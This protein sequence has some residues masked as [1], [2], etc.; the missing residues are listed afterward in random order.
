MRVAPPTAEPSDSDETEVSSEDDA[1]DEDDAKGACN[2]ENIPPWTNLNAV[3]LAVLHWIATTTEEIWRHL[4]VRI[5]QG[6][7]V[8]P[9]MAHHW[10]AEYR[11][12]Y[13]AGLMPRDC[14]F[15]LHRA[16]HISVPVERGKR[17]TVVEKTTPF[18]YQY[19]RLF[20]QYYVPGDKLTIDET[21]IRFEGA[22]HTGLR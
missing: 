6:I 4:A 3:R 8:L 18:Y 21:M 1:D 20:E 19:Q 22:S 13:C 15:Q 16:F 2:A 7:V 17:Q 5:R 10:S 14:F 9:H 11:D 12:A